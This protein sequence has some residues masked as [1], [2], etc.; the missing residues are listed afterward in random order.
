MFREFLASNGHPLDG[1]IDYDSSKF[2]YFKCPHGS[3][4]DARY[5]F[6]SD[7][8]P[9][10]YF[11]CWHCGIEANFCSKQRRDVSPVEWQAHKKQLSDEKQKNEDESQKRHAEV[12]VLANAVFSAAS[13]AQAD[14]H[15]YLHLKKVKNH[16]LRIVS[17]EDENTKKAGCYQGT[18]LVPCF[19][20]NDQLVNLERI[21]FDKKENKYQKRPLIGGQRNGAYYLIGEIS[22]PKNTL[23]IVEGASSG[24]TAYEATGYPTVIIW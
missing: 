11:K 10:G 18:L 20:E 24:F 15:D 19:N 7:G 9:S 17:H 21:Y 14:S 13:E 4:T 1:K 6:Y 23:W 12:A 3:S 2:H 8:I 22:H 16:G 5:R